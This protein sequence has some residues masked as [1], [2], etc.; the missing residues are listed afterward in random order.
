ML[1]IIFGNKIDIILEGA[2]GTTSKR[3][4]EIRDAISGEIL[5]VG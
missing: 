4:S 3:P 2:L 1:R 5:R